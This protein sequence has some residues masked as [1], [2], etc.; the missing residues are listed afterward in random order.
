MPASTLALD[1]KGSA[2]ALV[3]DTTNQ[4]AGVEVLP[5]FELVAGKTIVM[6]TSTV[7]DGDTRVTIDIN[8]L[9][10]GEKLPSRLTWMV[11][12]AGAKSL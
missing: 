1:L 6:G 5:P 3:F 2:G 9:N 12:V 4:G 7:T 10:A 8:G 11:H